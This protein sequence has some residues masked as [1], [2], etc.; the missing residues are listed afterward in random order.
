MDEKLRLIAGLR[1]TYIRRLRVCRFRIDGSNQSWKAWTKSWTRKR[2]SRFW[3]GV[4][5]I[6]LRSA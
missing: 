5:G 3:R 6:V 1:G 4:D 2:A